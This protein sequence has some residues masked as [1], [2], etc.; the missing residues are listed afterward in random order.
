M[1][2]SFHPSDH[3]CLF[4]NHP[5]TI[6]RC[7]RIITRAPTLQPEDVQEPQHTKS[8]LCAHPR[9]RHHNCLSDTLQTPQEAHSPH[10]LPGKE[11]TLHPR[12]GSSK[13]HPAQTFVFINLQTL[14]ASTQFTVFM[15]PSRSATRRNPPTHPQAR[16]QFLLSWTIGK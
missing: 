1:F 12:M 13:E 16:S 6:D 4:H 3:N 5:T 2:Q 8:I 14:S 9:P 15:F 10:P 7:R 11:T